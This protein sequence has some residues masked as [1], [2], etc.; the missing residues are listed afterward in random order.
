MIRLANLKT[1][2]QFLIL[3]V[4]LV[5]IISS[6][7]YLNLMSLTDKLRQ[8][9][10]DSLLS[11][12]K[13]TQT[14][15]HDIWLPAN[16][17]NALDWANHP[18]IIENTKSLTLN[19]DNSKQALKNIRHFFKDRLLQRGGKGIFI[20]DKDM[21][22]IASM[23]NK[24]LH[25]RNFVQAHYPKKMEQ[26]LKG[27]NV[28]IPPIPSDVP[29]LNE[30]GQ[31]IAGYPTMFIGVPIKDTN[32]SVIAGLLF[33]MDPLNE[34]TIIAITERRWKT[35][36]LYLIDKFARLVTRSRFEDT[37]IDMELLQPGQ[38]STL[39]IEV[40]EPVTV[41]DE[42]LGVYTKMAKQVLNGKTG[43]SK[44][45]YSDYR[46]QPVIGA[47]T[48]DKELELGITAEID[49]QEAME[50]ELGISQTLTTNFIFTLILISLAFLMLYRLRMENV[51]K[52]KASEQQL[53]SI[54]NDAADAIISFYEDGKIRSVNYI[55]LQ[56]LE[57]E[58]K[59]VLKQNIGTY[60]KREGNSAFYSWFDLE[61]V[62]GQKAKRQI[63][64]RAQITSMQEEVKAVRIAISK[65]A[66]KKGHF[67]NA[68][69]SDLTE[70]HK[71]E[72]KLIKFESAVKQSNA[73]IIITGLTGKIEYVNEAFCRVTGYQRD[74]VIGKNPSI[75]QSGNT[76]K[77]VYEQ[78]WDKLLNG[79]SWHGEFCNKKK[80]GSL[81]WES[82]AISPVRNHQGEIT[83]YLAVK[84]DIT[85]RKKAEEKLKQ[86]GAILAEA[87]RIAELGSWEFDLKS[88]NYTFSEQMYRLTMIDRRID[89]VPFDTLLARVHK[90][91]KSRLIE[92]REQA[93]YQFKPYRIEFRLIDE[94]NNEKLL[95]VVAEVQRNKSGAPVKLYGV[96][97]DI[98]LQRSLELETEKQN[99]TLINSRKV[100]LSI[101]EDANDQKRRAE[102]AHAQLA[103]SQ[104]ELA[105]AKNKAEAAN[106]SKSRFLATMSHEIRTPMNGV[107]G[108]L[109]LLQ[110]TE[111]QK[112][113][114]HL[115]NIAKSS[116]MALL[117]IINDILDFSKIEAGK[118]T[119]ETVPYHWYPLVEEVLELLG[120]SA[121][122]KG[123]ALYCYVA[124]EVQG[125]LIGDPVRLK[126]IVLNLLG[127]AIKF[128]SST[129]NKQGQI[130]V[131]VSKETC[132]RTNQ[133]HIA[134][135]VKDNGIGINQENQ[136]KLFKAFVQADDSTHRQFGGTGLGLSICLN[137]SQM[138]GGKVSCH[139]EE[140]KGAEFIVKL[141]LVSNSQVTLE[142]RD[143]E[144]AGLHII[145]FEKNEYINK[146]LNN[147]LTRMGATCIC[148]ADLDISKASIA[149]ADVLVVTSDFTI[150]KV[151]K[152]TEKHNKNARMVILDR[153][154][155]LESR[156]LSRNAV[157]VSTN[158]FLPQKVYNAIAVA[159]GRASPIIQIKSKLDL[160]TPVILP[161]LEQAE[162][163][164][165]LVLI[166]E[167]NFNNQEVI[168]RQLNMFG[169]V[170]QIADNGAGALELLKKYRFGLVITD[171]HMPVMDG[172]DLT[173][174]IRKSA[175]EQIRNLPIIAATANALQGEAEKCFAAGMNDYISKPIELNVLQKKLNK[176]LPLESK[177]HSESASV[178]TNE[179]T[180]NHLSNKK[181]K[182]N[183]PPIK[184]AVMSLYLGEDET[185]QNSFLQS[186]I[187]QSNDLVKIINEAH[188]R[189]DW[190]HLKNLS[191]K[192]KSSCATIGAE[193]L[194]GLCDKVETACR[195]EEIAVVEETVPKLLNEYKVVLSYAKSII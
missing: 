11:S 6:L 45:P 132:Q 113:Q 105:K 153:D 134:I 18:I 176:W 158:P 29:L 175:D 129:E 100:A 75:V 69:I 49:E 66:H 171:C 71:R 20:I 135:S 165:Q 183:E 23:R 46:G 22:N 62:I 79:K 108:M 7:N 15:L 90:D 40:R 137:L 25:Q 115:A 147:D 181:T 124:P 63:F 72:D 36:E 179:Q 78:L 39:N 185:L 161:S 48:W 42:K 96:A 107:V 160:A 59:K 38:V 150:S 101:M 106:E 163:D 70:A 68:V 170:V 162:Q 53:Q 149:A 9:T 110:Q 67:Y 168:K 99:E 157:V 50:A 141:P 152:L 17:R 146:V 119:L 57:I 55:A 82:A 145:L 3:T 47:W 74:E 194:A 116:A 191:H 148:S 154:L 1:H 151:A 92:H 128:T 16:Y 60:I 28:F 8:Q 142:N 21:V 143:N 98:S 120:E 83:H 102:I 164:G 56:L 155:Q 51:M 61:A 30:N 122:T 127:N 27:E 85:E 169:Y 182:N 109:D 93:L 64:G 167:D 172:F 88:E 91:D 12:V 112:D 94:K 188:E 193:S 130:F 184:R 125:E 33:R 123:L 177:V 97:R 95:Q 2:T 10:M 117:T 104:E 190:Q 84:E 111:L 187:K 24:N 80:N 138:M 34:F 73:A 140:G 77:K 156:K 131:T 13:S 54:L 58:E 192:F 133:E 189:K 4:A 186:F 43:M 41:H 32:S 26:L 139:S 126:Q 173:K 159:A 144:L 86:S 87:E 103:K 136:D 76:D 81:F 118:M 89:P 35:D 44:Q 5:L 180:G 195:S 174:A 166:A 52:L 114:S 178:L 19:D 121:K 31:E 65:H 14:L 37:L